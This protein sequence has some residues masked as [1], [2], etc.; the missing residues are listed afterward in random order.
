MAYPTIKTAGGV[1]NAVVA[2]AGRQHARGTNVVF[3]ADFFED[4]PAN[5][6]P[7]VPN[8]PAT[9]PRWTIVGPDGVQQ[10]TGV[11]VAGSQ[12]G[13]WQF[14]WTVLES[15][16]LSTQ[17][18]KWRVIWSMVSGSRQLEKTEPFDI[19][20]LIVPDTDKEE[21]TYG[22]VIMVGDSARLIMKRPVDSAEVR[23]RGYSTSDITSQAP[24]ETP[25]FDA[26]LNTGPGG[27]QKTTAGN[28]FAYY[29]DTPA[30]LTAQDVHVVWTV[31]D[32]LLSPVEQIN[33]RLIVPPR[34]LWMLAHDLKVIIDK[35]QKEAGTVYAYPEGALYSYLTNGLGMLSGAPPST[36]WNWSSFPM[37]AQTRMFWIKAGALFALE[38]QQLLEIDLTVDFGGQTI[39][40]NLD[41]TGSLGEVI[42]RWTESLTGAGAL[43]W[44]QVKT[45]TLRATSLPAAYLGV[46]PTGR[47][48]NN[49][50]VF[51]TSRTGVGA[52]SNDS[53]QALLAA[54]GLL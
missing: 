43:D 21:H 52:V 38:A 48:T 5:T 44:P 29:F 41:R 42:Q 16:Q 40:L 49:Q 54:L 12:V 20:D 2:A 11:A 46:R 22:Y 25:I 39:N 1:T 3:E 24:S 31:R 53:P 8:N 9:D 17:V 50:I 34:Q 23:V 37:N 33:Q 36:T 35:C 19:I 10:G 15:A 27:V 32:T 30:L 51:R 26:V 4:A 7:A 47:R 14:P 6:S 28:L 13:R 45:N 18:A